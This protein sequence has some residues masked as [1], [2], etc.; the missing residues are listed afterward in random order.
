MLLICCR[1]EARS[2]GINQ[3]KRDFM[4]KTDA[5]VVF[6][7][8]KYQRRQQLTPLMRGQDA[9][10]HRVATRIRQRQQLR[11][12][13]GCMV[14]PDG[15]CQFHRDYR[16]KKR[17]R[18]CRKCFK[19]FD[20]SQQQFLV[21]WRGRLWRR[22]YH[23]QRQ[24]D[25]VKTRRAHRDRNAVCCMALVLARMATGATASLQRR[26]SNFCSKTK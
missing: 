14:S 15:R 17:H 6:D 5:G 25:G 24:A 16:N 10:R 3:P 1:R 21:H 26:P 20:G 7:L 2:I 18:V 8:L 4:A 9:H 13:S 12:C 23:G 11:D 19:P 22:L